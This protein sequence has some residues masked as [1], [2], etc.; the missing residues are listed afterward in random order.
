MN[1]NENMNS[2]SK[3]VFLSLL[4]A[5]LSFS[6]YLYHQH[7]KTSSEGSKTSD[8][9]FVSK[10]DTIYH[11]DTFKIKE[12]IPKYVE[13]VKID[14]VFDS[15][16]NEIELVTERKT[17][18]DILV[19]DN[20]TVNLKMWLSGVH[21][22]VDSISLLVNRREIIKENT[23]TITNTVYKKKLFYVS[24][25]VGIGYGVFNKKAD[26]YVGIGIGMNL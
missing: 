25:Q 19:N 3:Y 21:T 11:K 6:L 9:V 13:K 26:F 15:K 2:N 20:D 12:F 1:K 16:G 8:T 24:P 7:N 4:M 14:T 23:I 22:N 18:E 5:F 17:Y 10:I